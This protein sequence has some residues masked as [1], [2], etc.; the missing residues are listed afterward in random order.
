MEK[1]SADAMGWRTADQEVL[2][3]FGSSEKHGCKKQG[4]SFAAKRWTVCAKRAEV[5]CDDGC[6]KDFKVPTV[7]SL[8]DGCHYASFEII[9]SSES[10]AGMTRLM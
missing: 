9:P 2:T 8:G 7:S 3:V 6:A 10:G 4:A 1:V 5:E